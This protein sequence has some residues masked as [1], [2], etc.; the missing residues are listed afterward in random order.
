MIEIF[1]LHT[2]PLQLAINTLFLTYN[3]LNCCMICQTCSTFFKIL[4]N[5]LWVFITVVKTQLVQICQEVSVVP[6]T[7]VTLEMAF[8]VMV[9]LKELD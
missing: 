1:L 9:G 8:S 7:K 2:I 5:V 6:V 4:M 3:I